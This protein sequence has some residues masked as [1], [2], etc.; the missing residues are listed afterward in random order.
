MRQKKTKGQKEMVPSLRYETSI[1]SAPTHPG[2]KGPLALPNLGSRGTFA[3]K[4]KNRGL[5]ERAETEI[6]VVG[7]ISPSDMITV[8]NHGDQ[9]RPGGH[10][11]SIEETMEP[12][13]RV[14]R[15]KILSTPPKIFFPSPLKAT[16]KK[17]VKKDPSSLVKREG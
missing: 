13:D 1:L 11:G 7:K 5:E 9:P 12:V 17:K 4:K 6:S 10:G 2:K 8:K 15:G 16:E 3:F 14:H